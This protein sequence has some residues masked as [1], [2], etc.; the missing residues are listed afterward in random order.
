[1]KDKKKLTKALIMFSLG[2][3]LLF[4]GVGIFGIAYFLLENPLTTN[5][6][7]M[8]GIFIAFASIVFFEQ[9]EYYKRKGE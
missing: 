7:C 4:I 3:N 1:M 5:I 2:K 8:A 9:A 6:L